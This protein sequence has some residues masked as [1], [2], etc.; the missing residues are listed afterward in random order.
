MSSKC[1]C[2]AKSRVVHPFGVNSRSRIVFDSEHRND[3]KFR[4]VI[5]NEN[6]N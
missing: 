6:R 2:G 5:K 4:D 1:V 3:C